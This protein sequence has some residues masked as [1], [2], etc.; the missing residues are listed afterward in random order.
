MT[1]GGKKRNQAAE[2]AA[3]TPAVMPFEVL[4]PPAPAPPVKTA[5]EKLKEF[6]DAALA[7]IQ[8]Y[9]D[10]DATDRSAVAEYLNEH[11][12]A[13]KLAFLHHLNN[14]PHTT[15]FYDEFEVV[16]D[17]LAPSVE[18]LLEKAEGLKVVQTCSYTLSRTRRPGRRK[19][20]QR[21]KSSHRTR[22]A[23]FSYGSL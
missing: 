16:P 6:E 10:R 20:R 13:S 18:R 2:V 15:P 22:G 17:R 5:A 8:M 23:A 19:S 11:W 21:S 1:K 3:A 7:A 14:H 9:I 12:E 4:R